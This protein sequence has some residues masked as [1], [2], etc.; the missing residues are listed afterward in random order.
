M[1]FFSIYL[2]FSLILLICLIVYVLIKFDT[3]SNL[4]LFDIDRI[5]R[6]NKNKV[7]EISYDEI[8]KLEYIYQPK[9]QSFSKLTLSNQVLKFTLENKI[10]HN[11]TYASL[12]ELLLN[13]NKN[14]EIIENGFY[15]K[16]KYFLH[17]GEVRKVQ[18]D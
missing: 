4:I 18:I 6:L 11:F 3:E 13:K 12:P 10:N 2:I 14:I 15:E 5:I 9:G 17:H 1:T 7:T 16:Y 8:L